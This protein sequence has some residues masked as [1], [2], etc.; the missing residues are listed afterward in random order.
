ML[1]T[2][3]ETG[4][5]I[6]KP[7]GSGHACPPPGHKELLRPFV[8]LATGFHYGVPTPRFADKI[9]EPPQAI[10]QTLTNCDSPKGHI[11]AAGMEKGRWWR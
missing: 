8:G 2:C 4:A 6:F 3:S 7:G 10:G 5:D 11:H 1:G 9:R